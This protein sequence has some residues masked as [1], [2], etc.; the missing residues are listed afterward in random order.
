MGILNKAKI[1]KIVSPRIATMTV[2]GFDKAP[3]SNLSIFYHH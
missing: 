3:V 2:M 1:E